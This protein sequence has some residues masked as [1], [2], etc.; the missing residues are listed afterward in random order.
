MEV[1]GRVHELRGDSQSVV[2]LAD[3]AFDYVLDAELAADLA[4][5]LVLSLVGERGGA[6]CDPQ[7]TDLRERVQQ[8][9]GHPVGEVLLVTGRAHVSERKD[10]D[11]RAV[12]PRQGRRRRVAGPRRRSR[13]ATRVPAR[14]VGHV[15]RCRARC[16]VRPTRHR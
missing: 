2:L 5:V 15:P 9:F 3:A 11:R 16:F 14:H 13:L 4:Q 6:T 12:S 7:L 1:V 10:G 8:L